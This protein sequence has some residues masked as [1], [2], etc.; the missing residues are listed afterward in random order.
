MAWS[1]SKFKQVP[2]CT[3]L[4]ISYEGSL[5]ANW[6]REQLAISLPKLQEVSRVSTWA[7]TQLG[8]EKPIEPLLISIGLSI[9]RSDSAFD[10][11]HGC[12]FRK[13]SISRSSKSVRRN[14]A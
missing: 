1:N 3:H 9:I 12:S 2:A 7:C 6:L 4:P 5:H 11:Y 10:I 14:S 8:M 13:S